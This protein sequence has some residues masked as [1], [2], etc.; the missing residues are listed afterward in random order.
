MLHYKTIEPTT[1]ELLKKLQNIPAFSEMRLVGGTSLALQLGHRSSIDI[2]LFGNIEFDNFNILPKLNKIGKIKILKQSENI[3]IFLIDGVKVD[4][5]NYFYKWLDKPIIKDELVL[6]TKKDI[7]AMKLAAI[8]GRGT[9]KDFIDLF[10][11]LKYYS[12]SEMLNFYKKKYSDGSDFMVLKSLTYFADAEE[13]EMPYMFENIEW[14]EVKAKIK[15]AV[16]DYQ[17]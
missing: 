13:N 15:E 12:V 3:N 1:L 2:D 10:F 11:L 5:V 4:I 14:N 6:S 8:T 9:K 17:I 16:I 7:S